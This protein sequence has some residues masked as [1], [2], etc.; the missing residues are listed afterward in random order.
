MALVDW[1]A[2]GATGGL[3]N[4]VNYAEIDT[5]TIYRANGVR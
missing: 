1:G 2:A 3:G 5:L 4:T